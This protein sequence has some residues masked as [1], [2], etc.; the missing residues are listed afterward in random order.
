MVA[1]FVFADLPPSE[2]L[3]PYAGDA[4]TVY[5]TEA[6]YSKCWNRSIPLTASCTENCL[7][8]WD[9][10]G[11]TWFN[12]GEITCSQTYPTAGL[13]EQGNPVPSDGNINVILT[14][15]CAQYTWKPP[16]NETSVQNFLMRDPWGNTYA[17][18]S[19][20]IFANSSAALAANADAAVL[21]DGWSIEETTLTETQMHYSYLIG[22]DCWLIVLKDSAGNAW[23]Q[24]I[25]GEPLEQSSLLN[26][27]NCSFIAPQGSPSPS[28]S[29]PSQPPSSLAQRTFVLGGE[30][31]VLLHFMLLMLSLLLFWRH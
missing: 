23:H 9:A 30:M 4:G 1:G 11:A 20:L 17:M 25:Y 28:S 2:D 8:F 26:S 13:S 22:D 6:F 3:L 16:D 24:Y 27:L 19:S 31:G 29:P 10:F 12:F 21:P 5:S 15:Q 7:E 18:Q 14:N